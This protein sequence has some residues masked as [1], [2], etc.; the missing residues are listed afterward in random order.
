MAPTLTNPIEHI[1]DVVERASCPGCASHKS[2][3]TARLA[4]F[5]KE[6]FQH[7][8]ESMPRRIKVVLKVTVV[9]L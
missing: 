4:N 9:L 1:W 5:S 6:C 3:S 7:L 8:V 2:P